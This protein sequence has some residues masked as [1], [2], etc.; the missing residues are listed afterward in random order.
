MVKS[1]SYLQ[2]RVLI[3]NMIKENVKSEIR[4]GTGTE[5]HK[6]SLF[7]TGL[8]YFGFTGL[9]KVHKPRPP[10]FQTFCLQG[11]PI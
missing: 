11:R 10:A 1:C 4:V 8:F 7:A 9:N 3:F 5:N 2:W 6:G